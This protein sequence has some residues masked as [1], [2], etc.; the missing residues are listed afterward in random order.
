M[1]ELAFP[2]NFSVEV[3]ALHRNLHL[4]YVLIPPV[5][6]RINQ[7]NS[8]TRTWEFPLLKYKLP[9]AKVSPFLQ[10]GPSF[11]TITNP[12]PSDPSSRRNFV[13]LGTGS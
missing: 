10:A 6:T 7:G 13:G 4:E 2:G 3:D 8:A 11:R 9:L 12:N 1:L 5:G